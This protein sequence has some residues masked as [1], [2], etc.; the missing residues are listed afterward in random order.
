MK[1]L[2]AFS[3]Y[4]RF[5]KYDKLVNDIFQNIKRQFDIDNLSMTGVLWDDP[6]FTYK[7]TDADYMKDVEL[8]VTH[9]PPN[10]I[11]DNETVDCSSI[12]FDKIYKFFKKE[13]K[14]RETSIKIN[15]L[16]K[17]A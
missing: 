7:H 1:Y 6:D 9:W 11:I 14:N 2:E 16:R 13:Y 10:V 17:K 12:M 5:N 4:N 15:K 3:F 8:E